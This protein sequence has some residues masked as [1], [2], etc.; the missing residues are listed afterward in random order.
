MNQGVPNG[1]SRRDFLAG[2][3][4]LAGVS[5]LPL[6]GCARSDKVRIGFMLPYTGT[7]AQLTSNFA[8][9]MFRW[10]EG[11]PSSTGTSGATGSIGFDNIVA[12]PEP[13]TG[14]LTALGL[15]LLALA[16]GRSPRRR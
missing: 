13:G 3:G 6:A 14:A 10:D 2:V 15:G 9:L 4:A 8:R 16:R 7:Y 1:Q 5:L 12:V 11:A